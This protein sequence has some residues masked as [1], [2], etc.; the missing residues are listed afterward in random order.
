MILQR[1]SLA[2]LL[3]IAKYDRRNAAAHYRGD[4]IGDGRALSRFFW[5]TQRVP[6]SCWLAPL[7]AARFYAFIL[8]RGVLIGG[9]T[10][11]MPLM[12]L[13]SG[14]R[15]GQ[16]AVSIWRPLFDELLTG[17]R[18]FAREV[19]INACL[20]C[21][22]SSLRTALGFPVLWPSLSW[23]P[24]CLRTQLLCFGHPAIGLPPI[25][26][27]PSEGGVSADILYCFYDASILHT[28]SRRPDWNC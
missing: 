27:Y 3:Q 19:S 17:A 21:C 28:F 20:T 24:S 15:S 1:I 10:L 26:K 6:F 18:A 22:A 11:R 7:Y 16:P 2:R 12:L 5:T 4:C 23:L 14:A 8:W 13:A 25:L 9:S